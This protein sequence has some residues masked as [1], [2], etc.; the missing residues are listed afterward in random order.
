MKTNKEIFYVGWITR[1]SLNAKLSIQTIVDE[2]ADVAFGDGL[3]TCWHNYVSNSDSL[4]VMLTASFCRSWIKAVLWLSTIRLTSC[5]SNDSKP[6]KLSSSLINWRIM[7][8]LNVI[9]ILVLYLLST[10]SG[11]SLSKTVSFSLI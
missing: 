8:A 11:H 9:V 7:S 6:Y 4:V 3:W 5:F 10:W 2:V 1:Y